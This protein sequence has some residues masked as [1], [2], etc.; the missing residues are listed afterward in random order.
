MERNFKFN[1]KMGG[2]KNGARVAVGKRDGK[3]RNKSKVLSITIYKDQM[4]RMG[5]RKGDLIGWGSD[6]D[7]DGTVVIGLGRTEDESVGYKLI[8]NNSSEKAGSANIVVTA[9]TFPKEVGFEVSISKENCTRQDD[10]LV[11]TIKPSS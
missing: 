6:V 3:G 1:C 2:E 8:S 11:L 5:W 9:P 4:E 7:P 10:F